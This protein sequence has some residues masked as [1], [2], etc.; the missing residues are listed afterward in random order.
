MIKDSEKIGA[1][2]V[3]GSGIAG[4]QA[5]L[6]LANSGLK[7]YLVEKDISIGG[8]MAQLDKT[9]PTNDCS[10]CILSPK[11]V[12]VGRHPNV[13]ILTRRTVESVEGE[14]GKFKV[15][16]TKAPRFIDLDKCT[17][18]GDC[19]KVC[20]INVP[21]EFNEGLSE[22][23]ATYR[24]FPQAIPSGFAIDK[25]GTSPCKAA[26]P[27]H[28][29]VQGYV[30]LIATG[31]YK[32]ALKL[33]K[34]DNPFPIV[35]GRVCNHPCETACMRGKVEEPIDIMHLKRFVADLDLKDETR[36][37]PEKKESK[38]KKIAV[39]GAGP[40]GLTCAYYLAAEGYDV[41]VFE[42][43][44]VAGGWLAV[45]IP[46][47]RLPKDVLKAEIKVIEDLGVKIHLNKAIGKDIPF[48]KLQ[49]EYDA[50]FIGC[51]TVNSSK[52]NIPGEEMQGVIHGVD[53]LKRVNLGEKVF[54]GDKVA[55]VGGGNVA[56]DAVRTAVRTGSKDVFI[57]YRRSRAEMPAAPEEIEEALEEG[58]KMEFLAA[59][60]RVVG[61]NGKVTGVE[62][63]RMELGEPD[64]SGRR[65]PVEIKGSEFIV[66]CDA[67]IPAIG[68]EADLDFVPK[69]SGIA[70]SKWKNFDVDP[71]TFASNVPGVFAGG[72]VV[73]GPQT[74]VKAVY[75]GKE[76][77][78][79]IDRYLKGED[80]KAGREKDWTKDLAD[81]AD[82]S[83]VEKVAR[84]K[85]PHLKPEMR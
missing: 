31:K 82:V 13:E 4:I 83:K 75:A 6:D 66:P 21:S 42:S 30:A 84:A 70:I 81:K 33:I 26:C 58:I 12:E 2:M 15:R 40:A 76:A 68:Q 7:V 85:Y 5:S 14:A 48:E 47:Y 64:A 77:A 37:I 69:E 45:G 59:P 3:V 60:K 22:R 80:V 54:L 27:T 39:V 67:L 44:P 38:G 57:L 73:T 1:V 43:L 20:P 78:V 55:V 19:A 10:A 11:L 51:G 71:V 74:V 62:C 35:C 29:S 16:M 50:V 28:I 46:E 23:Q 41:E 49:K 17:G 72:D 34:K 56:M 61:E 18:C 25:L 79:S 24:K 52:L 8:V 53:Y 36:Y 65:R 9:F 32:E 63:T